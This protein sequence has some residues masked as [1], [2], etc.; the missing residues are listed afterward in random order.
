M[1]I[2]DRGTLGRRKQARVIVVDVKPVDGVVV[3]VQLAIEIFI[4]VAADGL[5][6]ADAFGADFGSKGTASRPI[7]A[8]TPS[9]SSGI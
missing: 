3:P 2:V 5:E 9:R 1:Q 6:A 7:R 8:M 4:F